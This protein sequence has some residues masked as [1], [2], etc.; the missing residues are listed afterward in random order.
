MSAQIVELGLIHVA[1]GSRLFPECSVEENLRLGAFPRRAKENTSARL[2]KV[3]DL[4]PKLRQRHRQLCGTLSG[5]ERQMLAIGM[6]VMSNP[7]LLVLDEPTLG[8]APSVKEELL[9]S[10]AEIRAAGT[11]L[12]VVDGDLPFVLDLTDRWY[13]IALG[14]VAAVGRSADGVSDEALES[15]FFGEPSHG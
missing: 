14:R 11:Q 9:R 8:L 7:R 2:E 5:G 6:G 13:G 1:Q 12:V 10:I 15:L 3:Y 4:F